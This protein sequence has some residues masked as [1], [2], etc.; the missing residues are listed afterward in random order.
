MSL[1]LGIDIGTSSSNAVLTTPSGTV[2]A[3]AVR[4]HTVFRPHQGWSEHDAR[5]VWWE[6]TAP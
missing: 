5:E 2:I 1:L 4:E 6:G 3:T